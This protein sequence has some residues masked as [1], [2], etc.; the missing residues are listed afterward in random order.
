MAR[1]LQALKNLEAR[2]PAKPAPKPKVS[3]PP[4]VIE[5]LAASSVSPPAP[6][7]ASVP[8]APAVTESI[9]ALSSHLASL[10]IAI[11]D[12][13][14]RFELGRVAATPFVPPLSNVAPSVATSFVSKPPASPESSSRTT[15]EIERLIRRTLGDPVRSKPLALLMQRLLQ[16]MQQTA[17]KSLAFVGVGQSATHEALLYAATLLADQGSGQVLLVD[18]DSARRRLTEALEFGRER[19][20]VELLKAEIAADEAGRPTTV[21][22]LMFLPTGLSGLDVEQTRVRWGTV[23]EQLTAGSECVLVDAGSTSDPVASTLARIAD[24]TYLVVQLG[25]V[26]ANDAQKALAE[27]RAAGARVLGCIA[28]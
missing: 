14:G 18:A 1:M 23:L 6:P 22:K 9:D 28:T 26:E 24:A 5:R 25:T 8:S 21:E 2:T 17:A 11:Q 27:F 10:E 13:P 4:N 3:P 7:P 12:P 19:G 20:L 16:D 15:C